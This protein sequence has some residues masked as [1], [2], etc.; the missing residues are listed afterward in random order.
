MR[1]QLF[2]S[3]SK[4]TL[5]DIGQYSFYLGIFFLSTTLFISG[6]FFLISLIIS[7][8][9]KP[10]NIRSDKWN[11]ALIFSFIL[12][13]ISSIYVYITNDFSQLSDNL[14]EI[15][16]WKKNNTWFN[17]F[18]WQ[19]MFLSFAG[20]QIYLKRQHQRMLV[21]KFLFLGS[22]PIVISCFLQ[23]FFQ[24][25]GPF[26]F[27][28]GLIVFYLKPIDIEVGVTGIFNN[29]NY[30]GIWLS[31]ILPFS[32]LIFKLNRFKSLKLSFIVLT[33]I[34]TIYIIS[35]T[36]SR[37]S[38][39]GIFIAAAFMFSTKTLLI[40]LIFLLVTLML[41]LG[42]VNIPFIPLSNLEILPEKIFQRLFETNYINRLQSPRID[43]WGK[44]IKLII[45][46]PFFG[47]GAA[48]FP[49]LYLFKKGM[50]GAQ[51]THNI[52]LEIAQINGL[53]VAIVLMI[54]VS[55]LVYKTAKIIFNKTKL[56]G[57]ID[58]S[59]LAAS[60][61][62]ILSHLT[63]VTYYEGR[64]SLL[65]WIFLSGLRCIIDTYNEKNSTSK[66]KPLETKLAI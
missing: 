39:F 17:L 13:V 29:P 4:T 52:I 60:I 33:I 40:A 34:S 43:I 12:L 44:A 62:I 20:F 27:L 2:N 14:E 36:Y 28:N 54:F 25:Y 59:W 58:R 22:I 45:E 37:N 5:F 38:F 63:D 47:W 35:D 30:T 64:I 61:I 53:P 23:R 46:R 32:F 26:E 66:K 42:L 19:L 21:A 1:K 7:F 11:S 6:I 31:S 51:H 8:S 56:V 18:K 57:E 49:I 24:V 16:S 9:R 50:F 65:I 55:F 15:Q 3:I 10:I 48:T 41:V